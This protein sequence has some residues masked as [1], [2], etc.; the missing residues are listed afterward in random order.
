MFGLI[1]NL[2][3]VSKRVK[4][5][6]QFVIMF[7]ELSSVCS[8]SHH[9]MLSW[10]VG[11]SQEAEPI[12]P[13]SRGM[14]DMTHPVRGAKKEEPMQEQIYM[15]SFLFPPQFSCI[16]FPSIGQLS[17]VTQLPTQLPHLYGRAQ[18]AM[19]V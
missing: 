4:I 7:K 15:N 18:M 5:W 11:F 8:Q 14:Q 1:Q 10:P 3:K 9:R 6:T 12:W 17:P 16:Q 2:Q 13:R 19:I